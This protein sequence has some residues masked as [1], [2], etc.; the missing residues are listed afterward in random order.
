[1]ISLEKSIVMQGEQQRRQS[2]SCL[3]ENSESSI[4]FCR[5]GENVSLILNRFLQLAFIQ[6]KH[7]T[8]DQHGYHAGDAGNCFGKR[9]PFGRQ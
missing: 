2:F 3:L 9:K 7:H 1:M 8:G 6:E 4:I 5:N